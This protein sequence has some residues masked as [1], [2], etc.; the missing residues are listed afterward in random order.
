MTDYVLALDSHPP[1]YVDGSEGDPGRTVRIERAE[2]FETE[3]LALEVAT[4]LGMQ[5]GRRIRV[6]RL[7]EVM[8]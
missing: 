1:S 8:E 7:D 4:T 2:R 6:V 5:F 3:N